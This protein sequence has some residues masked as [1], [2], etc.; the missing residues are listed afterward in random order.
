M[1]KLKEILRIYKKV[2]K[3]DTFF[4]FIVITLCLIVATIALVDIII[5]FPIFSAIFVLIMFIINF[6]WSI[7]KK[8]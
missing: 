3:I 6:L 5:S 7:M 1:Y 4:D 8:L 2:L